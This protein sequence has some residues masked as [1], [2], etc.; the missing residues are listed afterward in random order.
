MTG[1][2]SQK[3][4]SGFPNFVRRA[5]CLVN[6]RC[7]QRKKFSADK[8]YSRSQIWATLFIIFNIRTYIYSFSSHSAVGPQDRHVHN[9]HFL[10]L[11]LEEGRL[12]YVASY[13]YEEVREQNRNKS[14]VILVFKHVG[15]A[16]QK[17]SI[18]RRKL[19]IQKKLANWPDLRCRGFAAGRL[20]IKTL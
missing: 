19:T 18:Q 6:M 12:I 7:K 5:F 2:Q 11:F 3:C 14:H 16:P 8:S 10:L 9:P 13:C 15:P 1:R 20:P 17:A 4:Q